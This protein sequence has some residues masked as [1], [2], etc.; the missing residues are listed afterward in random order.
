VS[1]QDDERFRTA[2]ENYWRAGLAGSLVVLPII[3]L[4]ALNAAPVV[5]LAYLGVSIVVLAVLTVRGRR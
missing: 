5:S 4:T 3:L 1:G 2:V